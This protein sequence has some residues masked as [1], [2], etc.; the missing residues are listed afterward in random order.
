MADGI[1]IDE[2]GQSS[3]DYSWDLVRRFGRFSA[4][5]DPVAHVVRDCGF[6]HI[7]RHGTGARVA[8]HVG[9]F[10]VETLAGT[11]YALKDRQFPR[12]IMAMLR[13]DE[14]SYEIV[15]DAAAFAVSAEQLMAG[16]IDDWCHSWVA[17]E[18][19]LTALDR[20]E[21]AKVRPLV[22]FWRTCRGRMPEDI[23]GVLG[24]SRLRDRMV[25]VR[26]RPKTSRLVFA[27]FGA[28]IEC[29]QPGE[30]ERL[31]DH[32]IHDHYDQ[33]Y[34]AWAATAYAEA[35]ASDS[36]QLR[37]I[38]ATIHISDKIMA[39][40]RY[41]RLILPWRSSSGDRLLMGISLTRDHRCFDAGSQI[42]QQRFGS[43]P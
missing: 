25:L 41:D 40:G 38:R 18:R 5:P 6:I 17:V 24:R 9:H 14:W 30:S 21:F 26:R 1:L 33:A 36:P 42:L 22:E 35:M 39:R 34:G 23:D 8:M 19:K 16:G 13:E 7:R 28:G 10:G 37:S 12:I 11:I 43:H 20:R 32:D 15:A 2:K 31:V 27:H 4:H 3:T 29:R